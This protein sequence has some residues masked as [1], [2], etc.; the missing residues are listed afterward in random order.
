MMSLEYK[1]ALREVVERHRLLWTRQLPNGILAH[2]N[3]ADLPFVDPLSRCPDIPAMAAAWDHNYHARRHVEDDL[4]PVARVSFGSA[5]FGAYLGAEVTFDSGAGWS[6]PMLDD[7]HQLGQLQFDEQS[8]WIRRQQEACRYFIQVAR[9][10]FALCET[11]PIDG[12][13]LV[14]LLR[15][16]AAYTDIYDYP[17]QLHC[18]LDFACQFNIRFIEM[19]RR[20]LAPCL[21]YQEGVFSMFRIWLPGQAVWVSVDAYGLCSP[22][23]FR[24]FG[25]PYLQQVIDHFGSGWIHVH[26]FALHLLPE[27]VKLDRIVGIG[28]WDDPNAPRGF[29]QLTRIRQIVGDIPLQIDC[30]AEELGRGLAKRSLPGGVVYVVREGV[31]TVAQA[32]RLMEKVRAYLAP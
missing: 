11:E 26:S 28:I 7:Y 25:A 31:E 20:I 2:I 32:N 1:P 9:G 17:Q 30:L 19:Q 29:D 23:V 10:K 21:V 12:L 8:A 13:N 18:L 22:A 5:A 14:E 15:G 27:V 4:L 3:P 6:R 24:E 16:S